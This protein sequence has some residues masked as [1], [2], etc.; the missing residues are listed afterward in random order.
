MRRN[1]IRPQVAQAQILIDDIQKAVLIWLPVGF[2]FLE[3]A[4]H[5]FQKTTL[6]I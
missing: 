1:Y 3:L 6:P 5:I 4:R 2:A